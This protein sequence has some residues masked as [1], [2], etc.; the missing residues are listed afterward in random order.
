MTE[1]TMTPVQRYTDAQSGLTAVGRPLPADVNAEEAFLASLFRASLFRNPDEIAD[2]G[3]WFAPTMFYLLK[4]QWIYEAILACSRSS[5]PLVP[6]VSTVCSVL[7]QTREG[8]ETRL[9]AVGGRTFVGK[10]AAE[11]PVFGPAAGY[12]RFITETFYRRQLIAASGQIAACGYEET[13]PLEQCLRDAEST[14]LEITDQPR[15]KKGLIPMRDVLSEILEEDG[16]PIED[17][18]HLAPL[19]PTSLSDLDRYLGGG[20]RRGDLV[21]VAARPGVGKTSLAQ[22]ISLGIARL[23][24]PVFFF[25]LEM[26]RKRLAYRFLSIQTGLSTQVFQT[27]VWIQNNDLLHRVIDGME[28]LYDLE[29][30]MEDTMV[31]SA[32]DVVSKVR[33]MQRVVG[34]PGLVVVDYLQR[35]GSW[36]ERGRTDTRAN[37]IEQSAYV[38]K[39]LAGSMETPILA[40]AQLNRGSEHRGAP[41]LS[42]LRDSGGIEQAADQVLLLHRREGPAE[43]VV[44]VRIAKNRDGE[45][46]TVPLFFDAKTTTFRS[47]ARE[48][49]VE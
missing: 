43:G 17:E 48:R 9:E 24:F 14:L 25:S 44:D 19:I 15:E 18:G 2:V 13:L 12:A 28:D 23:G 38:L 4:H 29:I 32:L 1:F 6:D 30:Y 10:L 42:D 7:R 27:D 37:E 11:V 31:Q 45:M 20:V 35:L 40:L 5:P 21:I 8:E 47:L 41:V 36:G 46:G 22:T 26:M 3:S 39:E 16:H 33:R 49:D 34:R